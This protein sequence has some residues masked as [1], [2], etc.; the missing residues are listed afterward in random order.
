MIW[1][2]KAAFVVQQSSVEDHSL[3]RLDDEDRQPPWYDRG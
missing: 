1:L 2:A 3:A